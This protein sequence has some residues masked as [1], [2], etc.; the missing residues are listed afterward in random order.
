M[1]SEC[2][3]FRDTDVTERLPTYTLDEIFEIKWTVLVRA[4]DRKRSSDAKV[5]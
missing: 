1:R 5:E 2:L 4:E 3:P